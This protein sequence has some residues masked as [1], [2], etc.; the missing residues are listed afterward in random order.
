MASALWV[1]RRC[2][3]VHG[4]KQTVITFTY[5][6]TG[7]IKVQFNRKVYG[8]TFSDLR[9]WVPSAHRSGL[10]C[11]TWIGRR[12]TCYLAGESGNR[13]FRVRLTAILLHMHQ[14]WVACLD[15]V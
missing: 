1:I 9:L 2:H 5:L 15:D 3:L 7:A 12:R 6:T 4:K 11:L 14:A 10:R 8:R 13:P